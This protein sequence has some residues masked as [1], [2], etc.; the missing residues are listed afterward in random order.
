MT[1]EGLSM[2]KMPPRT[3]STA[4]PA[5]DKVRLPGVSTLAVRMPQWAP[6]TAALAG[7]SA[8]LLLSSATTYAFG[9]DGIR[10]VPQAEPAEGKAVEPQLVWRS[11]RELGRL[12]R[13]VNYSAAEFQRSDIE[14]SWAEATEIASAIEVVWRDSAGG[15]SDPPARALEAFVKAVRER[16]PE[17][18]P[19]PVEFRWSQ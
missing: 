18:R 3:S 4:N 1:E 16:R 6:R 11:W 19:D 15:R 13:W 8:A 9:Q 2:A 5:V 14:M 17:V 10:P 7:L 12:A